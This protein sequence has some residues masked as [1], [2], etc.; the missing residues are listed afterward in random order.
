MRGNQN[1]INPLDGLRERF[2]SDDCSGEYSEGEK[3]VAQFSS[4]FI[5]NVATMLPYATAAGRRSCAGVT[6]ATSSQGDPFDAPLNS[7]CTAVIVL[8]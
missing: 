7:R 4:S 5:L 8:F 3:N 6:R 2:K 1:N